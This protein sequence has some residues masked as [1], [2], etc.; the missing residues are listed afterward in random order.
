MKI[1]AVQQDI[2]PE[3]PS[4]YGNIDY[5][6]YRNT[7]IKIDQILDQG[8]LEDR[9]IE[10]AL[11]NWMRKENK[12]PAEFVNSKAYAKQWKHFQLALR[13]NI[14]RQL[15]DESFRDFSVHLADSR[16][17]IWFTR[18]ET[19]NIKKATSKSAQ[20]R[21]SKLF[22]AE[23][24]HEQLQQWQADVLMDKN[25]AKTLGLNEAFDC[26]DVF[27]DTTCIKANIHFPVDWVLLRDAVKSLLL[28]IKTI[29][30]QGLKHRMIEPADLMKQMNQLSISM[31][32]TRRK[33]DGKAQRKTILRSMK[34]LSRCVSKHAERYR[35][36][37]DKNGE[38]TNWSEAQIKQVMSRIDN[39]LDQLPVAIKQAHE[40]I[41][42]ERVVASQDKIL[43]LYD[44]DV[45]VIVR[46]KA[47][48]EV[49]FGSGFLLTE[50]REGLILDWQLF[51]DQPKADSSLLKSSI[52][53]IQTKYG[54]PNAVAG[55]RGFHSKA[56][57]EWLAK[58][59][60]YNAVCPKAPLQ[61][62]ERMVEHEFKSMQTRRSQTEG[63]IGIFKNVF[64]GKPLKSKGY[65]NKAISIGISV[66]THNLWVIARK[67]LADEKERLKLAA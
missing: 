14:A 38:K 24:I 44:P 39:V 50:Q 56:N 61:L 41:I 16:L 49:E 10:S 11:I 42:G 33:K 66:L 59:G 63:R 5:K 2:S 36:L 20:E 22:D 35:K 48:G 17:F 9:L 47:G 6:N 64:L 19:F 3:I 31:T 53:R 55:D 46:G 45:H 25:K 21:F 62:S 60:I 43:S 51:K 13:C 58:Q 8:Q 12:N 28:A 7:L 52:T 65:P 37:L 15:T 54:N 32:H 67:A 1:L 40:R 57:D 23:I 26:R 18:L 29:R 4:L 27:M 34:K 30:A